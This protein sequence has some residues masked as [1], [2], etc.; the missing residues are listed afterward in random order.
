MLIGIASY[1]TS[2]S[3]TRGWSWTSAITRAAQSEQW[4]APYYVKGCQYCRAVREVVKGLDLN[5]L[6]RACPE[7]QPGYRDELSKLSG[8]IQVPYLAD[9]NNLVLG[10]LDKALAIG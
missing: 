4:L 5:V 9:D 1:S 3:N 8:K 10:R 2:F 6:N 7:G